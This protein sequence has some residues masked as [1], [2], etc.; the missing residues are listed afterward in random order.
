MI[1]PTEFLGNSAQSWWTDRHTGSSARNAQQATS[2]LSLTFYRWNLLLSPISSVYLQQTIN[3]KVLQ[4][5][6]CITGQMYLRSSMARLCW[7]QS[8]LHISSCMKVNIVRWP[9]VQTHQRVKL[10]CRA[11][12]WSSTEA[13]NNCCHFA[14][15]TDGQPASQTDSQTE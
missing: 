11:N 6:Q 15:R 14:R 13:E 2:F 12:S 9:F 3:I 5:K 10:W 1:A 8:E 4:I 7:R